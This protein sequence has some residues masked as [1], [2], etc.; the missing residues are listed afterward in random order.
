MTTTLDIKTTLTYLG[1]R[2]EPA[3]TPNERPWKHHA[4]NVQLTLDGRSFDFT[5]R[6][7]TAWH[8]EPEDAWNDRRTIAVPDYIKR[9][10]TGKDRATG[11][12][13]FTPAVRARF[14]RERDE[15]LIAGALASCV[16]DLELFDDYSDDELADDFQMKPSQI[17]EARA[18]VAKL[19]TFLGH[20]VEQFKTQYRED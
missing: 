10:P 15:K 1:Q 20:H 11:Q 2:E 12:Q 9:G 5:Y 16:S 18:H 14:H 17:A 19:R 6:T 4:Y 13:Q 7:G 3:R 8:R